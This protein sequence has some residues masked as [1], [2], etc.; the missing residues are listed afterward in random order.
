MSNDKEEYLFLCVIVV[1]LIVS[2]IYGYYHG[3]FL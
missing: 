1:I 3:M 2:G